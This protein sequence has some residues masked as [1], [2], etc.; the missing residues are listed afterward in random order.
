MALTVPISLNSMEIVPMISFRPFSSS[1][2]TDLCLG[3]AAH[4]SNTFMAELNAE[5]CKIELQIYS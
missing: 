1:S 3:M 5:N 2:T 4:V